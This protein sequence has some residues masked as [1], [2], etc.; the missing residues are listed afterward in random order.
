MNMD[1][2]GREE[3]GEKYCF[4]EKRRHCVAICLLATHHHHHTPPWPPGLEHSVLQWTSGVVIPC[5]VGKFAQIKDQPAETVDEGQ[6]NG[7][8][9]QIHADARLHLQFRS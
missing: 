1:S 8:G 6:L 3:R 5:P 7:N 2:A 9:N 4:G